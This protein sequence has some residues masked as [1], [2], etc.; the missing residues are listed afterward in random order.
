MLKRFWSNDDGV[1][2]PVAIMLMVALIGF[3]AFA[4]DAG[5][6]YAARRSLQNAVDAAALAGAK[7]VEAQALGGLGDPA[8]QALT[9]AANNGVPGTGG[10]CTSNQ[11]TVTYN[12][13]SPNLANSWQVNASRLVPLT[14]GSVIGLSNMCVSVTAV[15]VVT[16]GSEAK[17][18]PYAISADTTISPYA[19]PGTQQS[20][21]PNAVSTDPYCFVLKE[22]AQ[23]GSSG[24]FGI[25]DFLCGGSQ[26]KSTN[27]VNW[28]ETGYGTQP[29]ETVPGPIP[30]NQW[31][32][33]TYTG[34]TASAN[35][36]IDNWIITT[37]QNPPP[38][39]PTG[40]IDPKYEPDFRCP[41]IGLLPILKSGTTF[42][43]G[44]STTVIIVNFAV[45]EMV[46]VTT[47]QATGHQEIVGEFL[48]WAAAVGPASMPD[49]SGNLSG[50]VT[51]RLVQ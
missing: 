3:C 28:T 18:F 1:I 24:N 51:I 49:P 33:C 34:N 10:T 43:S 25:L 17:V 6:V 42:G 13:A 21:D 15:A 32:V 20:C 12:G 19:K 46:G 4:L 8:G 29:G 27:Y 14:F 30:P 16:N 35:N 48:Q 47:D 37:V 44:S 36:T 5:N 38:Y 9:W 22:G 50:A 45:F 11:P 39:C 40:F 2:A 26:Q 41:L 23:G 31:T 7:D